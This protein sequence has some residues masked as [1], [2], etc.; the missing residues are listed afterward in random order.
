[1]YAWAKNAPATKLPEDVGFKIGGN[2]GHKYLVLQ[3]LGPGGA[4]GVTGGRRKGDSRPMGWGGMWENAVSNSRRLAL[5][6]S[7]VLMSVTGVNV[8]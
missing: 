3:V 8:E 5:K 6:S 2:T 7:W 1:M 4:P